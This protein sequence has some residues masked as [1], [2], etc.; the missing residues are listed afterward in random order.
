M[1]LHGEWPWGQ[2]GSE[3]GDVWEDLGETSSEW[4]GNELRD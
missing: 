2:L 4:I 3:D 1:L